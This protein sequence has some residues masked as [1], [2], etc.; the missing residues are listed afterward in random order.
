MIYFSCTDERI[1]IS[2]QTYVH[3]DKIKDLG[4]RFDYPSKNWI[5]SNT[6][7]L[8]SQV[9]RLCISLGGGPTSPRIRDEKNNTPDHLPLE[10]E[11]RPGYSVSE[12][13]DKIRLTIT[14]TFPRSIWVIG[15]ILNLNP[16]KGSFFFSLGEEKSK[17][18]S[19]T[20]SINA[21]LWQN[22]IQLIKNKHGE[23]TLDQVLS[24]GLKG[25]F[26]CQVN[27]YK[28]RGYISL[29]IQDIDP[30]FTKGALA[31]AREK[32]LGELRQKNLDNKNKSL[33]ISNFPLLVGLVSADNSRAKSDFMD[34][35]NTYQFPGNV[36][37][38][39]AQMQ[40]DQTLVAVPAAI[41]KLIEKGCDAIVI[42]RGGGSASDLR[43]FDSIEIAKAIYSS[44]I[45]IV[46]AIGHHDDVCIAEE[47]AFRREKTPTAAADFLIHII[48]T[49]KQVIH[50]MNLAMKR[51][52]NNKLDGEQAR[53]SNLQERLLRLSER[54]LSILSEH[55]QNSS[56]NL[57]HFLRSRIRD[58]SNQLSRQSQ[59][60]NAEATRK[61][62][63]FEHRLTRHLQYLGKESHGGTSRH[64]Y[65]IGH[66]I[67][68]LNHTSLQVIMSFEQHLKTL[69][70]AIASKDPSPWITKGYTRLLREGKTVRK[71][72]DLVKGSKLKAILEDCILHLEITNIESRQRH[73]PK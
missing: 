47:I 63:F 61:L 42:T 66:L 7:S 2:G 55:L 18:S 20:I 64:E 34:Q 19:S 32:L 15:E 41:R 73:E 54:R 33:V 67:K 12:I 46:C 26:L 58:E 69:Q 59:S 56:L 14:E 65:E 68:S 70:N 38:E 43:W 36:V 9:Q 52:L 22:A 8:L 51:E 23:T 10:H 24:E 6:P 11:T 21:T 3:K 50:K 37:F 30:N 1:I 35:L 44:P 45:P 25:R 60:L 31:L 39:H 48:S 27:F 29:N 49:T 62:D 53:Q 28:D 5:L 57:R 4:A 72:H 17:G 40:G 71:K 13:M 16:R